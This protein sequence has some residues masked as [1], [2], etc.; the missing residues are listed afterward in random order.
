MQVLTKINLKK[1]KTKQKQKQKTTLQYIVS[2]FPANAESIGL[3]AKRSYI[4]IKKNNL[5]KLLK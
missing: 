1:T 4:I 5:I 2:R 3:V